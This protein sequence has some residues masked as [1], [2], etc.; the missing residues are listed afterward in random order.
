L[1]L[2]RQSTISA[3]AGGYIYWLWTLAELNS[4]KAEWSVGRWDVNL[5]NNLATAL[6]LPVNHTNIDADTTQWSCSG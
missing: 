2:R 5:N 4:E 3:S 6:N 1:Q